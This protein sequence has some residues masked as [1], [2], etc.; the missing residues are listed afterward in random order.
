LDFA[1]NVTQTHP[2][3]IIV[4]YAT[5]FTDVQEKSKRQN[6]GL[7]TQVRWQKKFYKL[8][9]LTDIYAASHLKD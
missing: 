9:P 5:T 7:T 6:G 1:H 8:L 2:K 4:K 3:K